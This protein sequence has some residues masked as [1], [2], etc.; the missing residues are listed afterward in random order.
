MAVAWAALRLC[1]RVPVTGVE[2]FDFSH[3]QVGVAPKA[4]RLHLIL[5]FRCLGG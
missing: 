2:F 5:G 4:I 1:A 3:G